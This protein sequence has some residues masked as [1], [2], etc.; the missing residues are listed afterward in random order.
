MERSE[1][2]VDR[3]TSGAGCEAERAKGGGGDGE[4]I[5]IVVRGVVVVRGGMGNT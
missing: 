2:G 1:V 3:R 4:Y 5:A